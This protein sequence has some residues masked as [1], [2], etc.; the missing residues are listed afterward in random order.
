M[1]TENVYGYSFKQRCIAAF[2]V[3]T[4][5]PKVKHLNDKQ[6]EALSKNLWA[7][8]KKELKGKITK[9]DVVFSKKDVDELTIRRN[10]LFEKDD[11]GYKVL[12]WTIRG[13]GV[14]I[15]DQIFLTGRL[16]KEP[17]ITKMAWDM[18]TNNKE[19]KR[20]GVVWE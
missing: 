8:C 13:N 6:L 9:K 3:H 20:E 10:D 15:F 7:V 2:L 14:Y 19:T 12:G 4:A 11:N 18:L 16:K 17:K 5:D 1:D